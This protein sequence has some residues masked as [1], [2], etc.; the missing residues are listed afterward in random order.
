MLEGAAVI[1]QNFLLGTISLVTASQVLH[2]SPCLIRNE[3]SLGYPSDSPNRSFHLV[4]VP[5]TD[6]LLYNVSAFLM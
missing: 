6:W 2:A 1:T 3:A 5:V 4:A